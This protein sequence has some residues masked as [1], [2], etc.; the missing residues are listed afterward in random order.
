MSSIETR[1]LIDQLATDLKPVRVKSL[2]YL[3]AQYFVS[4]L[5]LAIFFFFALGAK[6]GATPIE[7]AIASLIFIPALTA[8]TFLLARTSRPGLP[9]SRGAGILLCSELVLACLLELA[10]LFSG[11]EQSSWGPPL[12]QGWVCLVTAL[13]MGSIAGG[14][15]FFQLRGEAPVKLKQASLT[16]IWTS[17]AM[18]SLVLQVHCPNENPIHKIIWHLL[19]P[20]GLLTLTALALA[21]S[22]LRW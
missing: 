14:V 9:F 2:R 7:V 16:A 3:A 4:L 17:A 5:G 19:L 18:A 13:G 1:K 11:V 12:A 15:L 22:A 8:G 21:K 10:R 20:L 6:V